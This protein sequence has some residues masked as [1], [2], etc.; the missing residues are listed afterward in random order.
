MAKALE[1]CPASI[2]MIKYDDNA[3]AIAPMIESHG[4]IFIDNNRM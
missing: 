3:K 2:M 1:V 4:S